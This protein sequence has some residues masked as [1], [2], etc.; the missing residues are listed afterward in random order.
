MN[1]RLVLKVMGTVI[2]MGAAMMVP[3]CL[4]ALIYQDPNDFSSLLYSMG[5]SVLVGGA[6]RLLARPKEK[7]MRAKEAMVIAALSW[8][9][10]SFFGC[11]PFL[12]S[13]VLPTFE[14]AL[15]ETVSGFTTTGATVLT[16]F[17]NLPHGVAFWRSFTHWI[18]GMG[19][20][21]FTLA[22]MPKVS[23]RT[24]HLVRA[25]SPGPSL[26]KVVPKMGDTA[27]ILYIIYAALSALMFAVLML[28]GMNPYDA[29]IHMMGTAGT[30][31][32]SNY[33]QSI[34]AFNSP[35]IEWIITFFMIAFGINFALY[36][37]ILIGKWRE[38]RR[39]EE[40][41]WY[42]AMLLIAIAMVTLFIRPQ[43]QN[44]FEALRLGSFQVAS[45]V[46]TTG[47][48]TADFDLWPVAAKMVLLFLMLVGSCAGS[49]AGGLK[50]VRFS[51]LC[52]IGK[53]EVTTTIHPRKVK[54]IRVEGKGVEDSYLREIAVF[55]FVY[56][57]I[58]FTAAFAISLDGQYD[59]FTNITAALTCISNVG[60][61]FNGVGPAMNFANYS[62]MSKMVLSLVMLAGR[63]ELFPILVLFHPGIWRKC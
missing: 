37:Q 38:A 51:T 21:V 47:Y 10:L 24:S 35:L 33:A 29:A 45:I 13:G 41:H 5:I 42:L 23:G 39:N 8:M 16:D 17:E 60:P 58:M 6:M 43:C 32:F 19:V 44:F 50:V 63:L 55:F 15:F 56:M 3:S 59:M 48:A 53:R 28:A 52:K 4:I 40:L 61:G 36:Y 27:K 18:G 20:I 62:P 12:F 11:L 34:A 14:D 25:E 46:S 26:S 31:G 30:G 9:C 7:N 22:V 49:T 1:K 2:M 54:V 57:L